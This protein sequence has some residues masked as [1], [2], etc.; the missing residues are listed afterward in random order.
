MTLSISPSSTR[1]P[2]T[3][4]GDPSAQ[5]LRSG[6]PD[7]TAPGL[8]SGTVRP[9]EHLTGRDKRSAVSSG[10]RQYPAR[11]RQPPMYSSP[12][13]RS[14]PADVAPADPARKTCVFAR[15]GQ[16]TRSLRLPLL[17]HA[18][19]HVERGTLRG[20]VDVP[21][22]ALADRSRSTSR[23]QSRVYRI[24]RAEQEFEPH[25]VPRHRTAATVQ[26]AD[27]AVET[28]WSRRD[29]LRPRAFAA[30]HHRPSHHSN[31]ALRTAAASKSPT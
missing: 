12:G 15:G 13:R 19:D 1:K 9:P 28:A 29:G 10:R 11:G 26:L 31:S 8:P 22:P 6:R 18:V 20:T 25:D 17:C 24:R 23:S 7:A 16:S 14:R 2:R 30:S 3:S 5:K 4:P 27:V 21:A